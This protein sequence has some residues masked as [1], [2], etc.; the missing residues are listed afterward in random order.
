MRA[1]T[2]KTKFS[3]KDNYTLTKHTRCWTYSALRY[4]YIPFHLRSGF[5]SELRDELYGGILSPST[6]LTRWASKSFVVPKKV[7]GKVWLVADFCA[8][9]KALKR[10]IWTTESFDQIMR[11][12]NP[13]YAIFCNIDC[14]SAYNQIMI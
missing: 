10:P 8:L 11:H 2:E 4:F 14:I 1:Q 7:P 12:I 13:D 6:K 9:N 5:E 3:C